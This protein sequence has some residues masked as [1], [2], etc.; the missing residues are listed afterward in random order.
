MKTT[1]NQIRKHSPCKSGWEK[2]LKHLGKTK[3]DDEPLDILTILESNGLDDALWC[4]PTIEGHDV[5]IRKLACDYALTVAHLWD[6]P[7]IVQQYLETQDEN[8]QN[9]AENAA[10]T[11]WTARTVARTAAWAARAAASNAAGEAAWD[12]AE[13]ATRTAARAAAGDS[14]W[15]IPDTAARTTARVKQEQ[16]LRDM[17]ANSELGL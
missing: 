4:L 1:L 3:A 10:K 16:M 17:I 14:I 9:D 2:L 11:E 15:G 5:A 8:I 6:M 12:A 7:K 13:A